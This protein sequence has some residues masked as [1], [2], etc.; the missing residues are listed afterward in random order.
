VQPV[1]VAV[2]AKSSTSPR[3]KKGVILSPNASQLQL[4]SNRS[5]TSP[6][7]KSTGS[8]GG[9]VEG[10]APPPSILHK[11]KRPPTPAF[12]LNIP[13]P[14]ANNT[15]VRFMSAGSV[16]SSVEA[17]QVHLMAGAAGS[18]AS[19][20]AMSSVP[21]ENVFDRVLHA[22][23][24]EEN[25]RLNAMGMTALD[26]K[27]DYAA[28]RAPSHANAPLAPVDIDTGLRIPPST[29]TATGMDM[30]Y[31]DLNDDDVDEERWNQLH[32]GSTL[33]FGMKGLAVDGSG[34]PIARSRSHDN[35]PSNQSRVR[36]PSA[37]AYADSIGSKKSGR[38]DG[39]KWAAM[40]A[41]DSQ[42]PR[43]SGSSS[44]RTRSAPTPRG[45]V[46]DVAEF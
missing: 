4:N 33:A 25:Q 39:K 10:K 6:R 27:G 23:M 24:A 11:N 40:D 31:H 42:G 20:S 12:S 34:A 22:V 28:A 35:N 16:A 15:R 36:I 2:T 21:G 32:S 19:S 17:S 29:A 30:D 43:E 8:G 26:P 37:A 18:V 46:N 41:M 3:G 44:A 7:H 1:S 14:P 13:P 9:K 5:A 38:K 45:R